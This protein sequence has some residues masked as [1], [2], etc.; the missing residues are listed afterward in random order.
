MKTLEAMQAL[1]YTEEFNLDV[2]VVETPQPRAD[3]VLVRVEAA[4]VCGSDVHGV[5]SR[6]P[7]RQPP[8]IMG[9]ELVG[10]V[11]KTGRLAGESLLGAFVAVNPQIPCGRCAACRSGREN[12]CGERQ[13]VGGTRPGGFAEYVSVPTRC[14]HEIRDIDPAVA[15]FAEPL[16]TCVHAF[17]LT[18]VPVAGT[19]VVIGAGTIGILATQLLTFLGARTLILCDS[20]ENRRNE[21]AAHA[22]VVVAPD[23]LAETVREQTSGRGASMTVDAVGVETARA[24]S[25][26]LLEPGGSAVWLGMQSHD[27]IVPAFDVV[28]KEQ[29]V[30]GSFAYTDPEFATALRVLVDGLIKPAIS[31]RSVRIEESADVF[32]E[33]LR[34]VPQKTLKSIIRPN[35]IALSDRQTG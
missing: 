33:L 8:L 22:E 13:L 26:A 7:R 18:P 9:H 19:V 14:V 17:A 27:T 10:E 30:Q 2:R 28:V 25:L 11:V 21:A 12:I 3:E 1:M 4:G 35:W 24:R 5:A 15:V 29:R 23:D 20:D 32:D 6:S 31:H 34:G 16:A